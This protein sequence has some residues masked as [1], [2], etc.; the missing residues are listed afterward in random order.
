MKLI[1]D[2]VF[3]MMHLCRKKVND[4]QKNV[5]VKSKLFYLFALLKD[6]IFYAPRLRVN[7]RILQL[8]MGNH[9]L[10]MRRRKPDSIEV[11]QM[12][13]QAKDERLQ[14]KMERWGKGHRGHIG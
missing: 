6:F 5:S 11:Q 12:K 9:D 3:I 8:C 4:E 2:S 1:S 10:Y 14:K 13:A 7:K